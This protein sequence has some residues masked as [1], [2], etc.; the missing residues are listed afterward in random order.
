MKSVTFLFLFLI[1]AMLSGQVHAADANLSEAEKAQ[2]D[3]WLTD[4]PKMEKR[5]KDLEA[6]AAAAEAKI[7]KAVANDAKQKKDA[8]QAV[9]LSQPMSQAQAT[10]PAQS[11]PEKPPAR[12][13]QTATKDFRVYFDLN[14]I[15]RPGYEE[16]SFDTIHS[17]LFFESV[18][19]PEIQFSFDVSPSLRFYELDWQI[20]SFVQFRAG[21][22]S[23]PFDD[24]SPHNIY[25]GRVNVSKLAIGPAFLPDLWADLGVGAKFNLVSK[26][27]FSL[28]SHLYVVNGFRSGGTDPTGN[29]KPYPSFSDLPSSADNNRNK[30]IGT[31]F[32]GTFSRRLSVGFSYYTETWTDE[33]LTSHGLHMIGVDSQYKFPNA[34]S[35]LRVG[36]VNMSV[37][38]DSG[39]FYRGGSYVE[40]GQKLKRDSAWKLLFRGGT[41]QGDDRVVDND[42]ERIIGATLIYQPNAIQFS[43]EHSEDLEKVAT[44]KG[45]GF[46]NLRMVIA[47]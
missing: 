29:S 37:E 2:L 45:Y 4:L 46:T 18:I 44:K 22:I 38:V 27:N 41:L 25:G 42:D 8:D 34:T 9:D 19:S 13:L 30:A 1:Q 21:K 28:I 10:P 43:I 11:G 3:R 12:S 35:E 20:N 31:R 17:F 16:F 5:V 32:Q 39:T 47:L 36:L 26:P 14:L 6:R 23:I 40:F 7:S 33:G 15:R 24:L